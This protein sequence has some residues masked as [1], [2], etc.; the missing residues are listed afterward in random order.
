MLLESR[1]SAEQVHPRHTQDM[2]A[3]LTERTSHAVRVR[4]DLRVLDPAWNLENLRER[5]ASAV[6]RGDVCEIHNITPRQRM[7]PM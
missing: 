4:I 2:S 5:I 7:A 6:A 3:E 1:A